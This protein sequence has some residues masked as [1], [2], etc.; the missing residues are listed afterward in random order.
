MFDTPFYHSNAVDGIDFSQDFSFKRVQSKG[1]Q[2]LSHV[3]LC[4]FCDNGHP[5]PIDFDSIHRCTCGA[6]YKICGSHS[7]EKGVGD[8]AHELWNMEELDFVR[9]IPV[10]FCNIV[11]EKDFDRLLSIKQTSEFSIMER[12]CKY[13]TEMHLS[14]VWVKRL[15]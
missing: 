2:M 12:F 11:I 8:I 5:I 13:D 4:P 14:L 9:T 7:L 1:R 6:C 15:F 3:I 10:D